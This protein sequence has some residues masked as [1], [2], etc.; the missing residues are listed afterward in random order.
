MLKRNL[1]AAGIALAAAGFSS[2]ALAAPGYTRTT[3]YLRAGPGFDYPVIDK[4]SSKRRVEVLGCLRDWDWCEVRYKN[5][6]GWVSEGALEALHRNRRITIVEARPVYHIP[7]VSF[8]VNSY[9]DKHYKNRPFYRD[10]AHWDRDRDRHV[11][12]NRPY[13]RD[14]DRRFPDPHDRGRGPDKDRLPW[15]HR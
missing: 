8:S 10:R 9:W 2:A 3:V 12:W 5:D 4:L 11:D 7:V 13:D 15:D 6:R 1:L 14:R